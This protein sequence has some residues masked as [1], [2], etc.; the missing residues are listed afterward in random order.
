MENPIHNPFIVHSQS[1][2]SPEY[3]TIFFHHVVGEK[4]KLG[5]PS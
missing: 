3:P 2:K 1:F 4:Y 5:P